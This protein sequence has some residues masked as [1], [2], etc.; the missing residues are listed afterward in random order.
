MSDLRSTF[1]SGVVATAVL[2]AAPAA[3]ADIPAPS[4]DCFSA[5]VG[6]ACTNAGP[7]QDEDG[8]CQPGRC[9]EG[10]DTPT[11]ASIACTECVATSSAD[12]GPTCPPND[13]NCLAGDAG[14]PKNACAVEDL[15]QSCNNAGPNL[16]LA[17]FCAIGPCGNNETCSY[18]QVGDA[19][20]APKDAGVKDAAPAGKDGG[21][22]S[23]SSGASS[24]KS[25]SGSSLQGS[26]GCAVS[27]SSALDGA[28]F[29]A[30]G[31]IGLA[32]SAMSRRKRAR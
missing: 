14:I 23:S 8:I 4:N 19:G 11:D 21:S 32:G 28:W 1:L 25:S 5:A 2:L 27:G 26:S 7:N 6:S 13:P 16:N 20:P 17:G 10:S 24:A 29:F 12:A 18:C 15:G 9:K 30:L 3:F 31:A 22:H